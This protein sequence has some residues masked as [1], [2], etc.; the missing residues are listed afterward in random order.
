M[1]VRG[2]SWSDAAAA[3][4]NKDARD[5]RWMRNVFITDVGS[6]HVTRLEPSHVL[7]GRIPVVHVDGPIEDG[8]GLRAVVDMPDV[9][10]IRPVQADGH[11]VDGCNVGGRP[12]R[13]SCE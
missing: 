11:A 12:C 4:D 7:T 9:R 8:E 5:G 10:S 6:H 2:T 3:L 13:V 1:I